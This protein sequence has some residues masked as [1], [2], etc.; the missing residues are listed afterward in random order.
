MRTFL[1]SMLLLLTMATNASAQEIYKE[2]KRIMQNQEVIKSD[3]KKTLDER[4][5]ATFK[6]DAIYYMMV[7]AGDNHVT[8]YELGNQTSAMIDFVNLYIKRL[9]ME[10]KKNQRDIIMSR[11]KKVT[12]E[13]ALFN[14]M[15][16]DII[17]AYVDN[18]NF[19]TQ[20][21]LDTNWVKAL[22]EVR[23]NN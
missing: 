9:S 14:D 22:E 13:N 4:K 17:Y 8:A 6:Y 21:S 2:V 23:R 19:I 7:K 11:F 1:V 5:I 12:I 16:K 15:D 3:P 10:K 18:E 20:F